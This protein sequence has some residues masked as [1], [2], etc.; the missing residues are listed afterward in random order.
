MTIMKNSIMNNRKNNGIETA[1]TIGKGIG[2]GLGVIAL[3]GL[4][5]ASAYAEVEADDRASHRLYDLDS[6]YQSLKREFESMSISKF[7]Y[8]YYNGIHSDFESVSERY[9]RV[10]TIINHYGMNS[11]AIN[12]IKNRYGYSFLDRLESDISSLSIRI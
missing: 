11:R 12:E 10:R 8:G 2:E 5:F 1:K 3:L 7:P 9:S 4:T 6:N